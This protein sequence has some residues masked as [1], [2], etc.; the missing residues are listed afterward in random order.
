MDTEILTLQVTKF[1]CGGFALGVVVHHSIADGYGIALF[2][3][4]MSELALDLNF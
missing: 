1:K 2:L 3:A 4:A